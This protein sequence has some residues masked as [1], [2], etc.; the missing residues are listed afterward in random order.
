MPPFRNDAGAPTLPS[1]KPRGG[2]TA[3]PGPKFSEEDLAG[4]RDY[5]TVYERH[6][7][8]IRAIFLADLAEDREVGEFIRRTPR[9]VFVEQGTASLKLTRRAILEGTWRPYLAHLRAQG[10]TYA[11]LGFNFEAWF[12]VTSAFRS[13]VVRHLLAAYAADPGR[14][15]RA[16]DGMDR[17]LDLELSAI[18]SAYLAAKERVI[19]RQRETLGQLRAVLKG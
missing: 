13:H 10:A 15:A 4:I 5:W 19:A 16:V 7:D 9:K 12:R 17:M 11:N 3:E 6:Y 14:L 8:E 2:Q 18:G 1:S